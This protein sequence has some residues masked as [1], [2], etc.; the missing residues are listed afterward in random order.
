MEF[1]VS[2]VTWYESHAIVEY[3]YCIYSILYLYFRQIMEAVKA[4]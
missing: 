4:F 2:Y 1:Y 3:L